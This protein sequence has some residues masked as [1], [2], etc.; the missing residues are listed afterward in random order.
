MNK[1]AI[2][3]KYQSL[4]TVTNHASTEIMYHLSYFV[5]LVTGSFDNLA[6]IINYIYNLG[7]S[8]NA[9]N[10]NNVK[11]QNVYKPQNKQNETYYKAITAKAN[12]IGVF[13]LC[14]KI[15][16]LIDF[17]YPLRDAIQHRNFIKPLTVGSNNRKSDKL[18]IWFPDDVKIVLKR[19]FN[20][21]DFGFEAKT[22]GMMNRDYY[23]IYI[24]S[25]KVHA[26]IIELINTVCGMIDL[27]ALAP[28]SQQQ[29]QAIN[30]AKQSFQND[31]W[32]G[33]KAQQAMAY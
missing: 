15:S 5:I 7:F 11:L 25:K 4:R 32:V 3:L 6:W 27:T 12:Q 13:L 18:L 33:L 24:F 22:S 17:I 10:R 8:L 21:E 16:C 20:P 1:A 29:I 19:Y 14:D 26:E 23:D 9:I 2:E 28:V 31:P 30:A